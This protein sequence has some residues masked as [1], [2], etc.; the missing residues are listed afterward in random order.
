[1]F[2]KYFGY[3]GPSFLAK[4]LLKDNQVK[5]NQIVNQAIYLI[6]KLRN[7][8]IRKEVPENENPNKIISIVAIENFLNFN[9]QQKDKGL[10]ILTPNQMLQRL[11][12]KAGNT[13]G[14]FLNETRQIIYSLHQAKET[15]K[16]VTTI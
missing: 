2:T 11:P 1:M 10:K 9:N 6:K 15:T 5:N 16:K 14:N 12:I 13:S 4:H 3:Q 7:R 8:A